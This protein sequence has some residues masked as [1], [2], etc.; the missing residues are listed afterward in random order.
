MCGA[1][2]QKMPVTFSLKMNVPIFGPHVGEV[3]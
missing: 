1:E 2:R 3:R